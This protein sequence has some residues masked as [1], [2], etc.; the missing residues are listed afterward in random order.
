MRKHFLLGYGNLPRKITNRRQGL[1]TPGAVLA[2]ARLG[3]E[4]EKGEED[5]QRPPL[6]FFAFLPALHVHGGEKTIQW[7]A[8]VCAGAGGVKVGHWIG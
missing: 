8:C 5:G 2:K 3:A 4:N 6:A 1:G 7:S